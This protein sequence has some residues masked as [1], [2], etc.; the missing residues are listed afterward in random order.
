MTTFRALATASALW[1]TFAVPAQGQDSVEAA[2]LSEV[3]VTATRTQRA[4]QS[5]TSHVD[6]VHRPDLDATQTQSVDR[7]LRDLPGI[8]VI[9]DSRFG[10]EV[11][12]GIRGL[13][14]GYGT[15]R[16][17][18][19]LDGRPLTDEYLGDVDVAQY[20]LNAMQRIELVRGPA[21]AV[22]GSSAESGVIN[23][24]PRRGGATPETDLALSGGTF[25]TVDGSASHGRTVG[26]VDLLVTGFGSHTNGYLQNSIGDRQD[27]TTYGLFA[28]TGYSIGPVSTRFY[29][30]FFHGAGT[31]ADYA[32][33][34]WRLSQDASIAVT[35]ASERSAY[36]RAQVYYARMGESDDWF[37][38]G[39]ISYAQ[40]SFGAVLTQTYRAT[41]RQLLLGGVEIRSQAATV[42]QAGGDVDQRYTTFA[43]FLQDEFEVSDRLTVLVGL[44]ADRVPA[45]PLAFSYRAGLNYRLTEGAHLTGAIGRAFRAP[46]LSDR[47]LPP[48]TYYGVTYAGNPGLGPERVTTLELGA[49]VLWGSWL[50]LSTT[51]FSSNAEDFWDFLPAADAVNRPQ[52]IAGVTVRGAESEARAHLAAG[53]EFCVNYTFADARYRDFAGHAEAVGQR[54]AHSVRHVGHLSLAYRHRRGHSVRA[55]LGLVG[56][57]YTDPANTPTSRLPGFA[58]VDL[59]GNLA[60]TRAV[61][62]DLSVRNV[63]GRIY[64]TRPEFVQPGRQV[65]AG[66]RAT[67]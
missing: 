55:T 23:L 46:T 3:V 16:S 52:N 13:T 58:L 22:Y 20:P 43:G 12:V 37:G 36:L 27:W 35:V 66:L 5:L 62:L 28:N 48:V 2:H 57:R 44:R 19:L 6:V 31:D 42:N 53:L 59:V 41:P 8:D 25:G 26:P 1:T 64:R 30:S 51:A 10:Q 65:T 60:V 50:T 39:P 49:A 67:L 33:R 54:L 32:R 21:S 47:F 63:F 14:N 56:D 38:A 29:S 11:Q 24:I 9:G 4:T 15:E 61:T 7:A 17:L 18:V 34:I 45:N 40:R